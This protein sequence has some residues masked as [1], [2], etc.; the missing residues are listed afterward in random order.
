MANDVNANYD[1][2][3]LG[4]TIKVRLKAAEAAAYTPGATFAEFPLHAFNGGSRRKFGIHARGARLTR[5]TGSAPDLVVKN[6]FLPYGTEA[7]LNALAI[8]STVTI[9]GVAWKVASKV[10]ETSV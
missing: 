3:T 7:A 8:D 6:T 5:T 1:S 10:P 4:S 9:G 2:S